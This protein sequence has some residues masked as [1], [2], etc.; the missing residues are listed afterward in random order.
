MM[1]PKANV[2]LPTLGV[3]YLLA[4]LFDTLVLKLCESQLVDA[5]F[6]INL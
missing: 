4:F 3:S 6:L 1:N 2:S 5:K